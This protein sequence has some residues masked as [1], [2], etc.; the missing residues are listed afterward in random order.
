MVHWEQ[1]DGIAVLTLDSPPVNALDGEMLGAFAGAIEEIRSSD[2]AAVIITGAGNAFCAGADLF[3]VL[4]ESPEYLARSQVKLSDS[5]GRLFT[6]PRPVVAAVN[7]HAIAGGCVISSA[8]D[9]VVA[10]DSEEVRIGLAEL[11]V[12][13]PFPAWA[14]EI[15]RHRVAPQFLDEALYFGR[16]YD[17]QEAMRRG[18]VNEL[19]APDTLMERALQVAQRLASIPAE[20]FRLTKE[21]VRS[22]AAERA[23]TYG[24]IHDDEVRDAWAS[25]EVRGAMKAFLQRTFGSS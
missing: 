12:G 11:K 25:D 7:G 19:T 5:F 20:T 10:V 15:A 14:L 23:L 22:P 4:K 2:A 3:R 8:T 6:F 1:S 24:E 17:P 16:L 21:A 13:V 18:F 9:H